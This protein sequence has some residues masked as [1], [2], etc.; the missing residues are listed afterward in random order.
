MQPRPSLQRDD[1][2]ES[3]GTE[4]LRVFNAVRQFFVGTVVCK[5]NGSVIP[6]WRSGFGFVIGRL[7]VHFPAGLYLNLLLA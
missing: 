3:S 7:M 4:A 5:I 6:R 1:V 2:A